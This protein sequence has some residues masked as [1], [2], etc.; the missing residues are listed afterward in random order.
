MGKRL[1]AL[2]GLCLIVL[3]TACHSNSSQLQ[4]GASDRK[5]IPVRTAPVGRIKV[6]R[7]IDISGTLISPGQARLSSEVAGVVR[8]VLVELG[9]EVQPGQTLV[10]LEPQE[11]AFALKRAESVLRQTEAQL[12]VDGI[13]VKVPPPDE[14]IASVRLALANRDDARAQLAR[15]QRLSTEGLLPEQDLESALT[16][17][18]VTEAGYQSALDTVRSLKASLQD[19]RAAY[20][21]AQKKLNDSEIRAPV[22]GQISER[23]VQPGEYIRENTPVVGVVQIQPLKLRTAAQERYAALIRPGLLIQ[24]RAESYPDS[25]FEGKIAFVSPAV[26]QGTRTLAIEALVD[27]SDRRLK[28]GFFAKGVIFT[29]EDSDVLAVHQD[30]IS[31]MAGVSTVFVIDQGKARQQIV[32]LGAQKDKLVEIVDGLKGNE[33]LAITNLSQLATGVPVQPDLRKAH[34]TEQP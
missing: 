5:R 10:R 8:E 13:K 32:T 28:P 24:F 26:D 21:L 33:V 19:R 27:N 14:A 23:L 6:Q 18:K 3:L 20:E 4:R 2:A 12:E 17:V 9:Q 31:T 25:I 22:G 11:L 16:R 30:A 7:Q 34:A 15:A 1:A 29:R